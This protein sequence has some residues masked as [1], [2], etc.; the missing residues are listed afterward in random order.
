[1]MKKKQSWSKHGH[2][3]D[4]ESDQSKGAI[5]VKTY[6]SLWSNRCTLW[7]LIPYI[8]MDID[9][10][11][12]SLLEWLLRKAA[13]GLACNLNIWPLSVPMAIH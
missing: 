7:F 3:H 12:R 2:T 13:L 11:H 4:L 1:M 8:G 10:T 9:R 5:L 6:G